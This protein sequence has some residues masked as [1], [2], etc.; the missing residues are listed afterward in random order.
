M[1]MLDGRDDASSYATIPAP[2]QSGAA[3]LTQSGATPTD[4][5]GAASTQPRGPDE[6]ELGTIWSRVIGRRSFLLRAGLASAS[7][8]QP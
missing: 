7:R 8:D 1:T 2:T 3:E 6:L 4:D 5:T